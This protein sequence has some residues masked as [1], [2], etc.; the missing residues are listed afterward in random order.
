MHA[1]LQVDDDPVLLQHRPVL[2]LQHRAAAGC[3]N[4][5]VAPD[6]IANGCGFAQTKPGF[7]LDIEYVRNRHPGALDDFLIAV[8]KDLAEMFGQCPSHR[9]FARAHH[10]HQDQVAGL[11][12][13]TDLGAAAVRATVFLIALHV[14]HCKR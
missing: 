14:S 7:A 12:F 3:Q 5:V 8:H 4:H 13:A 6:Q 2:L 10:A 1:R 11:Q 9:G